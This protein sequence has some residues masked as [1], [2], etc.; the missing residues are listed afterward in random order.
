MQHVEA[1]EAGA[2]DDSVVTRARGW[3]AVGGPGM[4][5]VH[6]VSLPVVFLLLTFSVS[7]LRTAPAC[8]MQNCR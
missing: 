2:D 6:H 1:G 4:H 8:N 7:F 3:A 5:G